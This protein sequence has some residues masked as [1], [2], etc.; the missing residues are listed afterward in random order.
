MG[1]FVRYVLLKAQP[2][3]RLGLHFIEGKYMATF[4]L[5]IPK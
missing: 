4:G 5:H 1:W 3:E 2:T